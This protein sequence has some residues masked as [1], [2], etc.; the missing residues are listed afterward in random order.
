MDLFGGLFGLASVVGPFLGGLLTDQ[1]SWH[2]VF[3]V[4]VPLGLI[5]LGFVIAKMPRLASGLWPWIDWLG[6]L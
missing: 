6:T 4:N 3:Y 2:W 1:I 5:A